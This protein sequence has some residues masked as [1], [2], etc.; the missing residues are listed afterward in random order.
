MNVYTAVF[1]IGKKIIRKNLSVCYYNYYQYINGM[2]P[3][4]LFGTDALGRDLFAAI[5]AI[6]QADDQDII[7]RFVRAFAED[8]ERPPEKYVLP[9][10]FSSGWGTPSQSPYPPEPPADL[11]QWLAY[12]WRRQPDAFTQREAAELLG[13][14]MDAVAVGSTAA[15]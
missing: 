14:S 6:R 10:I 7:N 1:W 11:R 13:Y 4:Y 12:K 3:S 2:E 15:G 9:A 5:G 8:R